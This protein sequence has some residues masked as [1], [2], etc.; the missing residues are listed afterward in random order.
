MIPES[1]AYWNV[2]P[3]IYIYIYNLQYINMLTDTFYK[4]GGVAV[5][6]TSPN[7]KSW[8]CSFLYYYSYCFISIPCP[9]GAFCGTSAVMRWAGEQLPPELTP[10]GLE[11]WQAL[12]SPLSTTLEIDFIICCSSM[13]CPVSNGSEC[14]HITQPYSPSHLCWFIPNFRNCL[15]KTTTKKVRVIHF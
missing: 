13:P 2:Y 10:A 6:M 12:N 7:V 8:S 5:R 3:A 11:D 1:L 4:N 15:L 14:R 9:S